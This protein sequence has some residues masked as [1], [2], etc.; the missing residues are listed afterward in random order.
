MEST[1]HITDLRQIA[2]EGVIGAGKTSLAI[3]L[4]KF[5][6]AK[7]VLEKFEEN[8]F[9]EKFYE[10]IS[11]YAFQTQMFFLMSRYRQQ[12][13]LAQTDIFNQTLVTDYMFEKDKIFAYL[14]LQDNELKLYETVVS[15]LEKSIPKPDLVVY[16]QCNVDHLMANIKK[17]GRKIERNISK[18]YLQSLNEAYNYFFFR[19]R[20]SPLLIVNADEIDFVN[21]ERDFD[22][23]AFEILKP[24]KIA[25]YYN[26]ILK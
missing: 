16:L 17:R 19:Y 25:E 13:E 22:K 12:Q 15:L 23:L 2:I 20:S 4:A 26:P 7:A 10:D 21:N 3:K 8:P 1:N 6:N 9:L 5:L 11:H 14:N 24:R 18:E